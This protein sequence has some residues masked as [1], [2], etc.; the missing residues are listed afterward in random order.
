[1]DGH[2]FIERFLIHKNVIPNASGVLFQK[3]RAVILGELDIDPNLKTCGDWLFYLK[4]VSNSRV[5]FIAESLNSFRYHSESVIAGAIKA[6]SLG[7]IIDIDLENRKKMI[8]YLAI[9]KPYNVKIITNHNAH[10][11]KQ[12]KYRK[13][14][15]YYANNEKL[16][17]MLI[18]F[19][20]FD[21]FI[22]NYILKFNHLVK[23]INK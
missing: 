2:E 15:F 6:E 13:G 7:S 21:V 5:A 14:M 10:I 4:L 19:K 18:L 11:V 12:L 17:G 16:K 9:E 22:I 20:L 8:D 3:E 23:P 1:M